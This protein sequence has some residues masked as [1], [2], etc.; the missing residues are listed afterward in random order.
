MAGK[1]KVQT[2]V[3]WGDSIAAGGW[4]QL[5]ETSFNVVCNTGR[6]IRVVNS[7]TCGNPAAQAR[8]EFEQSVRVHQPDVVII[9]F[10][11][12]DQRFDGSRG[13]L[14][15]STPE[16]FRQHVG[17]MIRLC[18]EEAKAQVIVFGNHRTL[19]T[20]RLPSGLFYDDVVRLYNREA[21]AAAAAAG[22]RFVDMG[23]A[24]QHPDIAYTRLLDDDGVHLSNLGKIQ[25]SRLAAT[26]LQGL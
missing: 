21:A 4:P 23:E 12:N 13:A 19:V 22:V 8:K 24:L 2:V 16:E 25:Y 15:L 9:Q 20:L 5:L 3:V 14:P 7:G 1:Q 18:R 11:L 10:G 6:P 17:E 26:E